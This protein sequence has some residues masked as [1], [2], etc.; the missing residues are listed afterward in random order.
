MASVG[1]QT[2]PEFQ[3]AMRQVTAITQANPVSVTTSFAHNYFTGDIVRII[4]PTDIRINAGVVT[5]RD[6]GMPEINQKYAPIVVTSPTTFTMPIDSTN[7]QALTIQAGSLQAPQCVNIGE[8]NEN[9]W[10]AEYNTLPS[11]VRVDH[12]PDLG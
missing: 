12:Q 3:P 5:I 11:L 10:G 8:V 1:A 7:F 9:I 4:I 6:F 2:T